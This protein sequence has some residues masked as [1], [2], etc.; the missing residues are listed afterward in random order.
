MTSYT[1]FN[2]EVELTLDVEA[3][4]GFYAHCAGR[5]ALESLHLYLFVQEYRRT[6]VYARKEKEEKIYHRHFASGAV[7]KVNVTDPIST[8]VR[9]ETF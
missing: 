4:I 9:I 5:Q 2:L 3:F 6:P 1:S 7:E 8:Y